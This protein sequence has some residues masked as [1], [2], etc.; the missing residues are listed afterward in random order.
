VSA[1]DNDIIRQLRQELLLIEGYKAAETGTMDIPVGPLAQAFPNH[2]F[3]TGKLHEFIAPTPQ[4]AAASGGFVSA[5]S[6]SLMEKG[7]E[8]VWIAKKRKVFPPGL[9]AF[10]IR[11]HQVVFTDIQN[12]KNLLWATEEA[13]KCKNVAVVIAE[14]PDI[15]F[16][17]SLRL[18]LTIEES[19]ITGFL[20]RHTAKAVQPIASAARWRISPIRS[21]SPIPGISRVGYPC[22]NVQLERVRNGC[23]GIWELEWSA[24]RLQSLTPEKI[25]VPIL[26]PRRKTG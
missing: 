7:G 11:P 16:I 9:T 14:I 17:A 21:R 18:Q 19:L 12:E 5:L 22:W 3:P 25:A 8:C 13:L 20:L 24:G 4:K 15:N 6:S 10:G 1:I 26:E 23:P 2:R